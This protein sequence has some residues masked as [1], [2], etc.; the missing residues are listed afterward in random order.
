MQWCGGNRTLDL[1]VPYPCEKASRGEMRQGRLVL[2]GIINICSLFF[3][4]L[5]TERR[6]KNWSAAYPV[7]HAMITT[8]ESRSLM[9]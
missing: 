3:D 2:G 6:A 9:S 8:K 5:N 4:K 7:H 1:E